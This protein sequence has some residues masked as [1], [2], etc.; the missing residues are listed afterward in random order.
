MPPFDLFVERYHN[1]QLWSKIIYKISVESSKRFIFQQFRKYAHRK[2]TIR[3]NVMEYNWERP[4]R[5][6]RRAFNK[7]K[8]YCAEWKKNKEVIGYYS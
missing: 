2:V 7:L 4:T 3:R 8:A 1:L 5:I 6:K